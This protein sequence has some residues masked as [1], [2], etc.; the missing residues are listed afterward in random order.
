MTLELTSLS[1]R[2]ASEM[3]RSRAISASELTAAHLARIES[4]NPELNAFISVRY[5]EAMIEAARAD[6]EFAKGEFRSRLHGLPVSLKDVY[7]TSGIRTTGGSITLD[8]FIPRVD[9]AVWRNLRS[10]GAILVGKCNTDEFA[11]GP[12]NINPFFGAV[13][14]PWRH[15]HISGGSSGGSAAAVAGGMS[16]V[17]MGTDGG[18]SVRLPAALCGCVGLKPTYGRVS[19]LG[20]IP[21]SPS[22][23]ACGPL[24]RT[25]DD[26]GIVLEAVAGRRDMFDETAHSLPVP[27]YSMAVRHDLEGLRVGIPRHFFFENVDPGVEQVISQ[28]LDVLQTLGARMVEVDMPLAHHAQEVRR[29]YFRETAEFHSGWFAEHRARYSAAA[30]TLL[31]AACG[32]QPV[33][34]QRAWHLRSAIAVEM[35]RAFQSSDVLVTPTCP[36]QTPRI[37]AAESDLGPEPA[38]SSR[39]TAF[40]RIANLTGVPAISVPCG[41]AL[42]EDLP[43]G[44]QF[45]APPF[46][47][48]RLIAIGKVFGRALGNET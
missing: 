48:V 45:I 9:S 31:D 33:E 44:L 35:R 13:K 18:G 38:S 20:V 32:L 10:C 37:D 24:T 47:E 39:L 26:A 16:F 14:N 25:V 46:Q 5:D 3:L 11:L 19:R 12:A 1:I 23:D 28:A 36:I 27:Q 29:A 42:P 2:A 6:S 8:K 15:D 4:L 22:I 41:R 34:L 30:R 7:L 17:S 21:V 43:V 40:T